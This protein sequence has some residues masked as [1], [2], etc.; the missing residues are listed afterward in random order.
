[1]KKTPPKLSHRFFRWYCHR[2]Y[3]ED[4][5]GDLLERF[6]ANLAQK[7]AHSARWSFTKDVIRLFRPGIIRSLEGYQKLNN[8]G[9]FK[10]Y[11]K[12]GIRNMLRYKAFSIINITGLSVG[13]A[14]CMLIL[15]YV[16]D[17]LS[18]DR[19]HENYNNIYRV[20]HTYRNP[21]PDGS[22]P[23][24]SP[25]E[26]Q[27]WGSAPVGPLLKDEFA[28]IKSYFRF[29]SPKQV[30]FQYNDKIFQENNMIFADSTAFKLFSW[31]LIA[32][33]RET[34][35]TKPNSIVLTQSVAK[36]YFGYENPLGK[37]ITVDKTRAYEVTGVMEDI[38]ANSHFSFDGLISMVTFHNRRPGIFE[39]W[40]YVDFYTYF[41]VD[42][43][44]D[45]QTLKNQLPDFFQRKAPE[46]FKEGNTIDIEPLADAYLH[47]E[48]KRQPGTTG[49]YDNIYI[50]S[51][52]AAF[53]LL[54]AC[55][56]FMNLST[57]RSMERAKE[58]GVR[59]A[60]GALQRTLIFQFLL[61][62]IL[63][64]TLSG[65]LA[66]VFVYFLI[67][68]VEGLS[69]KVFNLNALLTTEYVGMYISAIFFIGLLAG[70]YPSWVLA[71]FKSAQV[72]K[73]GLKADNKGIS[74]RKSLVVFQ[75]ALSIILI[76]GTAVVYSQ[77]DYLRTKDLGFEK[78]HMLIIDF[79]WD[80]EVQK[81]TESIKTELLRHPDV[82]K[83]SAS[84]AV[85]G[86][87]FPNAGTTVESSSGEMIMYDPAIYEIDP[88]FIPIYNMELVAGRNFSGS[89]IS[90]STE[91][92]IINEAAAK[93]YGYNNPEDVIGK[94]FAQWGREGQVIG[95]LKDFNYKSLHT[96]VEPLT[97]RFAPI[98]SFREFSVKI[99][100]SNIQHT[101][102]E[103]KEKWEEL[104]PQRPFIY[105]FLNDTF[106]NQYQA[107]VR[108]GKIFMV[109][110]IIAILIACLGLFG[111]T[112]YTT[113]QRTK[114]IG[115]R[116]VLG[117]SVASIVTL[118]SKDYAKLF[119]AAL[120]IAFPVSW[121]VM[122][123]WLSGFAYQTTIGPEIFAIAAG[124]TMLLAL[125]TISWQ[126]VK[127]AI[128]NP[129]HTLKDE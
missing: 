99:K 85:P 108:F 70:S 129:V 32:G 101:I 102:S 128:K 81:Q 82:E 125:S 83:V 107:D 121:Y 120:I 88:D 78:E 5:E 119:V 26:F 54:I 14:C 50:F 48:A 18:F 20:I 114:E 104:V 37:T 123:Q 72:L 117:A 55:I 23:A 43:K 92:L 49:S 113:E 57:A 56:N 67:P 59:K 76:V 16:K 62:S 17:E 24:P 87:F 75:F 89:N 7:G 71:K 94:P 96:R 42:G 97:L 124:V 90:D 38:P 116:K 22:L 93:L 106:N 25:D 8:Y 19:Y 86:Q 77:L 100:S 39:S 68:F 73:G 74:V 6:E 28:A 27:V 3:L 41:L 110:A 84:R 64:A 51:S 9:M 105:S 60:I 127:A 80:N 122:T 4:I 69:G 65:I 1:M 11:L 45:I 91:A 103:L 15:L 2:D 98:F 112:I 52:I 115:I 95:V 118:L 47:S 46:D 33:N 109:F 10:N 53:I 44:S 111:L 126:S 35:L 61:E 30:L 79:G 63:I 36:K 21:G 13:I 31:E 29:T 34:A 40:G 58:I 12:V 66:L